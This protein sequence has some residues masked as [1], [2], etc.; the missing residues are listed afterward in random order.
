MPHAFSLSQT[1]LSA[2]S[3]VG[4]DAAPSSIHS[5]ASARRRWSMDCDRIVMARESTDSARVVLRRPRGL[6]QRAGDVEPDGG[7]GAGRAFDFELAAHQLHQAIGEVEA[8]PGAFMPPVEASAYLGEGGGDALQ[9][10]RRDPDAVVDNFED[11]R[12]LRRRL[13]AEYDVALRTGELDRIGD[14]LR[15]HLGQGLVIGMD[16]LGAGQDFETQAPPAAS[17]GLARGVAAGPEQARDLQHIRPDRILLG[18]DAGDVDDVVD[19]LE[20]ALAAA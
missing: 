14:E 5:K 17:L 2:I 6:D 18:L 7:A 8:E 3:A 11:D 20:Q 9:R 15:D 16:R 12:L 13:G 10:C 4:A 19:Q 1:W